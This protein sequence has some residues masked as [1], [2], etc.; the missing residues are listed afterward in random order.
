MFETWLVGLIMFLAGA[1]AT[2]QGGGMGDASI[3]RLLRL[4]RLTRMAR[5]VGW[6]TQY[7]LGISAYNNRTFMD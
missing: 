2:A 3:L 4:L 6:R 1:D 7:L 5:L